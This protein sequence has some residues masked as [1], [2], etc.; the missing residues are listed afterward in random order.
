M[1]RVD[2]YARRNPDSLKHKEMEEIEKLAKEIKDIT[3]ICYR[4]SGG[5]RYWVEGKESPIMDDKIM[6]EAIKRMQDYLR[7]IGMH[8]EAD[9][10]DNEYYAMIMFEGRLGRQEQFAALS[11]VV[12]KKVTG[13]EFMP[14]IVYHAH[15]ARAPCPFGLDTY[16]GDCSGSG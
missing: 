3:R 16:G 1:V 15:E 7:S 8:E 6:R 9:R 5:F 11:S 14:G 10:F 4:E 13:W 2:R 12:G